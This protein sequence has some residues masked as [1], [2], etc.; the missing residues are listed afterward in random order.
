MIPTVTMLAVHHFRGGSPESEVAAKHPATRFVL[1]VW[2][3]GDF[4]S[5]HELIAPDVEVYLNGA[6]V[7]SVHGGAALVKESVDYWRAV[8]PDLVMQIIHECVDHDT[9]SIHWHVSGTLTG[10]LAGARGD[11]RKVALEGAV[12][13]KLDE[14]RVVAAWTLF[15]GLSL[16]Q[17]VGAEAHVSK[18]ALGE[19]GS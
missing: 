1:D 4:Q 15:D 16:M 2:N 6:Q 9:V 17:Q 13:L 14:D 12:F 11:G 18:G 19:V 5:A 3:G 8:M 7:Q 10:E